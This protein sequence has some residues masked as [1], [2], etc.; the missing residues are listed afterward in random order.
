S[1]ET[2]KHASQE[3]MNTIAKFTL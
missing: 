1:T 2:L 3:L